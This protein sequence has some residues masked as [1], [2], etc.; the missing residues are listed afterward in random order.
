MLYA[1]NA[2]HKEMFLKHHVE[3]KQSNARGLTVMFGQFSPKRQC[4]FVFK[5]FTAI[6]TNRNPNKQTKEPTRETF[7]ICQSG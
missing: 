4:K 5:A 3:E 2:A 7:T 6:K 1:R